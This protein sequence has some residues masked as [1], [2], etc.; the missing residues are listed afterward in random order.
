[1]VHTSPIY[2]VLTSVGGANKTAPDKTTEHDAQPEHSVAV[3]Q[4]NVFYSGDLIKA[5]RGSGQRIIRKPAEGAVLKGSPRLFQG[6]ARGLIP[7][8]SQCEMRS[9]GPSRGTTQTSSP[10][11]DYPLAVCDA[12]VPFRGPRWG[13]PSEYEWLV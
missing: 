11:R 10:R 13:K 4:I 8:P 9:A 7:Q 1:M 3:S 6:V 5:A 2:G 12:R